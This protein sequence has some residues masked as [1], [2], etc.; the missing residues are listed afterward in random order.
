MVGF[1]VVIPLEIYIRVETLALTQI[2]LLAIF[3]ALLF[4][5]ERRFVL[6]GCL[7][8]AGVFILSLYGATAVSRG[9]PDRGLQGLINTTNNYM[10]L[11][12]DGKTE[13]QASKISPAVGSGRL[14]SVVHRT[15]HLWLF[16]VVDEKSPT[17]VPYLKGKSYKPLLTSFIPRI[18]YLDKPEERFGYEFGYRYRF[19]AKQDT[20]MSLNLPWMV[21]LLANFGRSG[22]IWG[23]ALIGFFLAILDRVF[24]SRDANDLDFIVGLA[25][26][27]PLVIPESNFSLMTSSILPLF[28]SLYVYFAG[29]AWLLNK[30]S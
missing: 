9:G 22:V 6:V 14:A 13:S 3:F 10:K 16:H 28:V 17:Q 4:L 30:I 11:I 26:I 5:F 1:F 18:F 21:E 7:A 29:G 23:M 19:I 2:M 15:S 25:I 20:H 12:V 8:I 27:F 24:N